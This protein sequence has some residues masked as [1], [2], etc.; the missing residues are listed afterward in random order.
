MYES[1]IYVIRFVRVCFLTVIMSLFRTYFSS[2]NLPKYSPLIIIKRSI[3]Q[4]FLSRLLE[5]YSPQQ[6]IIS[7]VGTL[8]FNRYSF[9]LLSGAYLGFC[10]MRKTRA[11]RGAFSNTTTPTTSSFP[12]DPENDT[13]ATP[14]DLDSDGESDGIRSVMGSEAKK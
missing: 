4:F 13:E 7:R 14:V 3:K 6:S 9:S 12:A 5:V 1:V 10:I 2:F 11:N 8:L